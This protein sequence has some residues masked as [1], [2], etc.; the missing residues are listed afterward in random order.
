MNL[1]IIYKD[2][3]KSSDTQLKFREILIKS[4]LAEYIKTKHQPVSKICQTK[5]QFMETC[6]KLKDNSEIV[7]S[8]VQKQRG[9]CRPFIVLNVIKMYIHSA[10]KF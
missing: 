3:T 9:K 1:Y 6:I 2:K 5:Y 10:S 8:V 7:V 4:I